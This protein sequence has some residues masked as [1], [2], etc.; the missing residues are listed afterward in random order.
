LFFK[1]LSDHVDAQVRGHVVID[2]EGRAHI[3]VPTPDDAD[4]AVAEAARLKLDWVSGVVQSR[5]LHELHGLSHMLLHVA[6]RFQ[7]DA[8]CVLVDS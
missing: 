6:A 2:N 8:W 5:L 4:E 1:A 7:D 3:T